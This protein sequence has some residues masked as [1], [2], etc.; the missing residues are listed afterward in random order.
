MLACVVVRL[1]PIICFQIISIICY[2][3]LVYQFF[4]GQDFKKIVLSLVSCS[5]KTTKILKN[6]RFTR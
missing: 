1:N 3:T 5:L 6:N 4:K 2:H